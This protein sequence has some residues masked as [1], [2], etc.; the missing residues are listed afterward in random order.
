M[1]GRLIAA[2][3]VSLAVA[4]P[5]YANAADYFSKGP[6][7]P[8]MGQTASGFREVLGPAA[9]EPSHAGA[10]ACPPQDPTPPCHQTLRHPRSPASAARPTGG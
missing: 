3:L 7:G 4:L 8:P 9:T 1:S 2:A 10:F 5:G 6:S